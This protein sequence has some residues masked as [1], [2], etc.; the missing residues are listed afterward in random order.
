METFNHLFNFLGFKVELPV[1]FKGYV[2]IGY[3]ASANLQHPAIVASAMS[4]FNRV[5]D[6]HVGENY[7]VELLVETRNIGGV[8]K[9]KFVK[10]YRNNTWTYAEYSNFLRTQAFKFDEYMQHKHSFTHFHEDAVRA[11][12]LIT[13][14]HPSLNS[15]S[16]FRGSVDML[17]ALIEHHTVFGYMVDSLFFTEFDAI[18]NHVYPDDPEKKDTEAYA[19]LTTYMGVLG[20]R[21]YAKDT[22]AIWTQPDRMATKE[23]IRSKSIQEINVIVEDVRALNSHRARRHKAYIAYRG[24]L[25]SLVTAEQNSDVWKDGY[26]LVGPDFINAV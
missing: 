23:D 22:S 4:L 21:V 7:Y 8:P 14:K 3:L 17:Q 25:H 6:Y 2:Q 24:R 16:V 26:E 10:D 11:R 19:K 18:Y 13:D 1:P 15:M 9:I 20:C 5:S 12:R